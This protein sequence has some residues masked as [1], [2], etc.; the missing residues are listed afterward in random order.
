TYFFSAVLVRG[1]YPGYMKRYF[2]EHNIELDVTEDDLE[3]LKNTVDFISFSYYLS[4][5]ETA[6]ESKR[7]AGAGNILGGVQNPYLE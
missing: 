4:T 6:D 7:T 1:T 2:R 5:T 3:I